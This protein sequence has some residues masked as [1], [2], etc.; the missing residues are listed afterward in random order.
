M[1]SQ[2]AIDLFLE[3]RKNKSI[4]MDDILSNICD[5]QY[6]KDF[7][8]NQID[9]LSAEIKLGTLPKHA[10]NLQIQYTAGFIACFCI[11]KNQIEM[12]QSAMDAQNKELETLKKYVEFLENENATLSNKS[13]D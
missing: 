1:F 2:E 7:L 4:S 6:I 12:N 10:T 8:M 13:N 3:Q 9:W 11:A 5:E